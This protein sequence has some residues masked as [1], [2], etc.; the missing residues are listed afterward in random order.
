MSTITPYDY[1]LD[2][3][4]QAAQQARAGHRRILIQAPVGSGK[5]ITSSEIV[6]RAACKGRRVLFLAHRRRLIEQKS[7]ALDAFGVPHGVLMSGQRGRTAPVQVASRDTLLS[8]V[9]RND[10]IDPPPADLV[11]VDEC[12]RVESAEFQKLLAL[13]PD[14]V[15]IGFTATPAHGDGTPLSFYTALV[16]CVGIKE[17]IRLGKIVGTKFFA[18]QN[19]TAGRRKLAGDP[20]AAWLKWGQGRSTIL[21]AST[22]AA[23]EAAA[24]AFREAGIPAEH[25]DG[26]TDDGTRD[27][28]ISRVES[29]ETKIACNCA[30]AIE[31]WDVP[32]LSC[33]IILRMATSYVLFIQM[34]GRVMRSFPGKRE[35]VIV[36]HAD[37]VLEH[38]FPEEEVRWELDPQ[39]T[40]E[41][42]NSKDKKD[43][44]RSTPIVCPKCGAA[45]VCAATC[46]ECGYRLPHRLQPAIL[47]KQLLTEVESTLTPQEKAERRVRYWL[48]CLRVMAHK[49]LTCGAAAG[50]FRGRYKEGPD[51]SLPNYPQGWQWRAKVT[52][53]FPQYVKGERS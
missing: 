4:E 47:K 52:E 29:G 22:I 45:Y 1:Q 50:M 48:E 2:L 23:S 6:R 16:C 8:R 38:G 42:R 44:K 5:T 51:D 46:P 30:V 39:T 41:Q 21:F 9:V 53:A 32:C 20:V 26:S 13:Y 34:I 10:W 7:K 3:V 25:F 36:D 40:I 28:I 35:A 49:G 15:H 12:H 24:A 18:P 11:I 43:G 31:G 27:A 14:A 19:R 17:L 37:A 33:C